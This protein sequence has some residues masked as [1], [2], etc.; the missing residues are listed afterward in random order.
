MNRYSVIIAVVCAIPMLCMSE[1][2]ALLH[3]I[4]KYFNSI[5]TLR[6]R[7]Q[8]IN[9]DMSIST[10]MF[11]LAK[12]DKLRW[13]YTAPKQ[14]IVIFKDKKLAYYD[15]GLRQVN[16]FTVDSFVNELFITQ[17]LHL[18][19]K[20]AHTRCKNSIIHLTLQETNR[21]ASAMIN[22]FTHPIT[23]HS[24]EFYDMNFK[25][26]SVYFSNIEYNISLEKELFSVQSLP[27]DHLPGVEL[28][29]DE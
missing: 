16:Y 18:T 8:Q 10:G 22:F 15:A 28:T 23:L 21:Q 26:I 13:T 2:N 25:K 6:A 7:F 20:N 27:Q 9:P 11:Y 12:P 17:P 4:E 3:T 14:V 24:I 29:R 1:E 19:A 5:H